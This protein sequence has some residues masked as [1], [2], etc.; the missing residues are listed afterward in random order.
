[1]TTFKMKIIS[2]VFQLE[3]SLIKSKI[4]NPISTRTAIMKKCPSK[5]NLKNKHITATSRNIKIKKF[6]E[7]YEIDSDEKKL[8]LITNKISK[9][10]IQILLG[11]N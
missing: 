6:R 4:M 3:I 11:N 10:R 8:F 1:M 7:K 5:I 2:L 9:R